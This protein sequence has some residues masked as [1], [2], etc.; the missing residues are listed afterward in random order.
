MTIGER[1]NAK[2]KMPLLALNSRDVGKN[3]KVG[4]FVRLSLTGQNQE[5]AWSRRVRALGLHAASPGSNPVL[6]SG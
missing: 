4:F 3:M 1:L 2:I 6:T 5:A